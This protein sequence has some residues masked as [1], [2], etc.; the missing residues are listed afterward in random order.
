MIITNEMIVLAGMIVIISLF[1]RYLMLRPED[2]L[3][4]GIEEKSDRELVLAILN[5]LVSI[6]LM[7]STSDI[8]IAFC[9]ATLIALAISNRTSDSLMIS[10]SGYDYTQSFWVLGLLILLVAVYRLAKVLQYAKGLEFLD[11]LDVDD[12]VNEIIDREINKIKPSK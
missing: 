10:N 9:S 8:F 7:K 5:E 3:K 11:S 1:T 12:S 6:R 2:L 4:D